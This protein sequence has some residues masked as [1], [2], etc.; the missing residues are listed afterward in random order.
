MQRRDFVRHTTL[1]VAALAVQRS[2]QAAEARTI[3]LNPVSGHDTN[4]GTRSAP[5]RTLAAAAARVN[6]AA[7]PGATTVILD[8]GIYAVGETALIKPSRPYSK[9]ERLT[10]RAAVLPDDPDWHQ[11]R[12]P[13][14][15]HTMPLSA[16]WNGRPDPFGGVA[17][18][19][20]IE[21]SHVTVQGLRVLGMP[22]IERP[23]EGAIHRLYAVGLN[24]RSLDDLEI[25]QCLFA[26]DEVTNPAHLPLL[27]QG[28]G[29]VVDH[30]VFHGVKQSVVYWTPG[31]TGHALRNCL[32]YGCKAGVWTSGIANDFDYRNNV[33]S[34]CSFAWIGQGAR[35]VQA[36]LAGGRPGESGQG[37]PPAGGPPGGGPGRPPEGPVAP[38]SRYKVKNCLLAGNK[39]LT[40]SGAGPALNFRDTDGSLLT[41]IDTTITDQ[42]VQLELDQAKR[43]YLHPVTGSEAAQWGAGLFTKALA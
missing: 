1:A 8:E 34:N 16:D 41:L 28:N 26:G 17:Y 18:G 5:L 38:E 21:T 27:I 9:T 2:S 39:K 33:V 29:L 35:S 7:E 13:T 23:K 31:S 40:G 22:I 12:M 10:I 14:L 32:I 25:T 20:Q 3:Y 24:D 43:N 11:S 42:P 4:P 30:C 37:A 19:M 36:E 6:A 15:I